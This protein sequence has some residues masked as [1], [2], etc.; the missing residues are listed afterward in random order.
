MR[1]STSDGD[2]SRVAI[3]GCGVIA[4]VYATTL[5]ALGNVELVAVVDGIAER[6]ATFAAAHETRVATFEAVIADD[7]IDAIVNLTPPLAHAAVSEASLIAGKATFSE[8]PLGVDFA[9]GNR[10]ATIAKQRNVRLGCAPDTFLGV[11]LQTCRA[12]IDRGDIGE[13]LSA[14]GFMMGFGPEWWHPNP[15]SFYQPG[16]GPMLDMGPYYLT[17]LIQML[18][19]AISITASAKS[20]RAQRTIRAKARRGELIDVAV[21]THV[22][23]L[24][25]FAGGASATLITSFDVMASRCR[26]IEIYGTEATLSLPDPNTFGGP[27]Q[28]RGIRDL[29]WRD[30]E[31]P[32]A[33]IPQERGIGLADM[34]SAQRNDRKHR[35]NSDLALH[36]L[37]LMTSAVSSSEQGQRIA[38]TTTCERSEPLDFSLPANTFDA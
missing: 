7:S 27:V 9:Q 31:L 16:A 3:I 21:P 18:G 30:L 32:E 13:P 15:E 4:P 2:V 11:G 35:A 8:K 6:A 17:A 38:L 34:L 10:L 5:K 28:I 29:E 36:V 25:D 33:N 23:S 19:P 26:N 37:E 1:D 20:P 24:I 22:S 14:S 12:A